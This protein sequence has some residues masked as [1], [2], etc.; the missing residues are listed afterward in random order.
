MDD[1]WVTPELPDPALAI[2]PTARA[3]GT[4][5]ERLDGELAVAMAEVRGVPL[6]RVTVERVAFDGRPPQTTTTTVEVT[7]LTRARV[8]ASMFL[9]PFPCKILKPEDRR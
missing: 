3:P 9:E 5:D 2:W 7:R 4:G 6:R 1:F 8:A